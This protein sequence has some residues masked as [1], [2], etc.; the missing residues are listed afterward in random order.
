MRERGKEKKMKKILFILRSL[1]TGGVERAFTN[2]VNAL[3]RSKYDITV[4][5]FANKGVLIS[6]LPS[7]V[8]IK[9]A[10]FLLDCVSKSFSESKQTLLTFIIRNILAVLVKYLGSRHIFRILF[11][12]I[13]IRDY[14]DYVI[15]YQNDLDASSLYYGCNLFA[16]TSVCAKS[17]KIMWMH[18]DYSQIRKKIVTEEPIYQKFDYIINVSAIMKYKF[19]KLG[20]VPVSKSKVVYNYIPCKNIIELSDILPDSVLYHM[21]NVFKIISV[22]RMDK[23]KSVYELCCLAAK[24][25]HNRIKFQWIFCGAGPELKRCRKYVHD[26]G[27]DQC[28]YFLGEVLNPYPY[29]KNADIF[30]SGSILESFGMSIAEALVLKTPV[31]ALQ[32]EAINEVVRNNINGIV[33]SDFGEMFVA[34]KRCFSSEA[35]YD[36]LKRSTKLLKDYNRLNNMQFEELLN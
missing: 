6:E 19:D 17:K 4:L 8:H 18:S 11:F 2:Q 3:D 35:F 7:Y 10:G 24:L 33:V 31:I 34:I 20:I 14:Y 9:H 12:N 15:A 21:D 22:C 26:H 5:T 28:V 1:A 16:L 13:K 23:Q 32:Y 30:V 27:L 25:H 29:V 36:N